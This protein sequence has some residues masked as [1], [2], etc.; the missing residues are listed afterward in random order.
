MSV[1]LSLTVCAWV[2]SEAGL[3]LEMFNK[4]R[5]ISPRLELYI[6]TSNAEIAE[7]IA[8]ET[9][10]LVSCFSSLGLFAKRHFSSQSQP[11]LFV[12]KP[13]KVD[14]NLLTYGHS[15]MESDPRVAT[16]SFLNN[17]GG[18]LG[19]GEKIP[20]AE[21]M[22]KL[23][24]I[25]ALANAIPIPFPSGHAVLI[26]ADVLDVCGGFSER[27]PIQTMATLREFGIQALRR[28]F[29]NVAD[30]SKVLI[31]NAPVDDLSSEANGN[32]DSSA[33]LA[34]QEASQNENA[35]LTIARNIVRVEMHGL[36]VLIDGT[37]LGPMEMG[38]QVQ[39]LFLING[40]ANRPEI[41]VV[42]VALNGGGC[43]DYAKTTLSHPKVQTFISR[44]LDF[45]DSPV[46]DVLH[47][48][49]QP[50]SAIPWE[51]WRA[52][53][54][55]V[56][57]SIQ[58]LIAYRNAFYFDSADNWMRYRYNM[59]VAASQADAVVVI[60]H[61]VKSVV[62]QEQLVI[63]KDRL[64]VC[65]NGTDHIA[66]E[67]TTRVPS[68]ILAKQWAASSF[69]LVLGADYAHKNRDLGV[70]VWREL[71]KRGY[72]LKLVL[73]GP[74]VPA[75]SSREAEGIL[76]IANDP[77]VLVL[78]DIPSD[79]RNWLMKYATLILYPSGAEGFGFVPFEAAR[80][81]RPTLYVSFGPLKEVIGSGAGVKSWNL[82]ALTDHAV[83]LITDLDV[84]KNNL[85]T[86]MRAA[87][88][89][90]WDRVAQ[91]LVCSYKSALA[92]SPKIVR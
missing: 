24:C 80:V 62:E 48:P 14:L 87:N 79:E 84:Q 89:Y 66:S 39:T 43:P 12:V 70:R 8:G 85:N 20:P 55:R 90:T 7:K 33:A 49:Y 72:K 5:S 65:E 41:G 6:G 11:I 67:V 36:S 61:D 18:M 82:S 15:I 58:D 3:W 86:I 57:I 92:N 59:R 4:F 38:T 81:G 64:F 22:D 26:N 60:S 46:V 74:K 88:E 44:N 56:I 37:C 83:E 71:Q 32:G 73:S 19:I 35:P 31:S 52:I 40:L 47:R 45:S 63:G 77:D 76:G 23:G 78:A 17:G 69:I 10:F 28:G 29:V 21:L 1:S 75:G 9:G 13:I 2:E 50:D 91:K 25:E 30:M 34:Y 54:K 27:Y 51:R 53:A 68:E 16:V 42:H